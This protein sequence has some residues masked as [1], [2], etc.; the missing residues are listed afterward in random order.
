MGKS[1]QMQWVRTTDELIEILDESKGH[2]E[3][4]S[5][6]SIHDEQEPMPDEFY[7]T[8]YVATDHAFILVFS[9]G[10][11]EI[12]SQWHASHPIPEGETF[13]GDLWDVSTLGWS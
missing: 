5:W 13:D 10:H 2:K 4:G 7:L 9:N 6:D 3:D 1:K 8:N 11:M 12:V